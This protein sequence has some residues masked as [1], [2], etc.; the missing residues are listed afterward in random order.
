MGEVLSDYLEVLYFFRAMA[1]F[2]AGGVL[3]SDGGVL[4]RDAGID[5]SEDVVLFQSCFIKPSIFIREIAYKLKL[6]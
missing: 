5:V 1:R 3:Q 6:F 4:F 2:L